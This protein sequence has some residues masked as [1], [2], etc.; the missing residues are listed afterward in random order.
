MAGVAIAIGHA[1]AL[2]EPCGATRGD[3]M[4]DVIV[5]GGG[6]VGLTAALRVQQ[7]GARVTVLS[8]DPA[9]RLV[10]AVA[11]AVWYPTHTDADPRVLRWAAATLEEF[12]RQATDGV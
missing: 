5:V 2:A 7:R 9:P 1:A 10:S 3:A 4:T 6:I 11:A 8:A 12:S